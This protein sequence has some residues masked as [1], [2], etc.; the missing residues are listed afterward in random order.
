MNVAELLIGVGAIL[1][2]V[3]VMWVALPHED[4]VRWWLRGDTRETVYV[5]TALSI[6]AFG[7][8]NI[9]TALVPG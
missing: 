8:A 4:Q 5:V 1:V 9:V 6:F 2:S 3:L 7:V